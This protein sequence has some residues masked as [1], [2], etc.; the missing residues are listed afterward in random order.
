MDSGSKRTVGLGVWVLLAVACVQALPT[1]NKG[2]PHRQARQDDEDEGSVV[3]PVTPIQVGTS[4]AQIITGALTGNI[5]SIIKGS[6]GFITVPEVSQLSHNTWETLKGNPTKMP[7]WVTTVEPEEAEPVTAAVAATAPPA[8]AQPAAPVVQAASAQTFQAESAQVSQA[9]PAPVVQAESAPAPSYPDF[10]NYQ[11][12]PTRSPIR[13]TQPTYATLAPLEV[14]E[15]LSATEPEEK[16]TAASVTTSDV[17]DEDVDEAESAETE[18]KEAT[19]AESDAIVV[20]PE[21]NSE[22]ESTKTE[23]TVETTTEE[24]DQDQLDNEDPFNFNNFS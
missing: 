20:T 14:I 16:S 6:F 8:V 21:S 9:K 15:S 3:P 12:S 19:T 2:D 1:K 10:S 5:D 17:D 24:D 4:V 11:Y 13:T 18:V 23:A 22:T 7:A